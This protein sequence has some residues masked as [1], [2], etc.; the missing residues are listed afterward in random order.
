[1]TRGILLAALLW[2]VATGTALAAEG[3]PL[4]GPEGYEFPFDN[5]FAATVVGTPSRLAA[6][7]PDRVPKQEIGLTLFPERRI[8]E[9]FW[10]NDKLRFSIVRQRQD[11]A[12]LFHAR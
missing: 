2:A 7:L 3:R 1:M 5:A 10:Y 8:P 6:E 11:F 9:L 12:Q 4:T